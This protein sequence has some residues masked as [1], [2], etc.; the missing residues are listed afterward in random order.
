[1]KRT[2]ASLFAFAAFIAAAASA[3]PPPEKVPPGMG[4][5]LMVLIEPGTP[6]PGSNG[7]EVIRHVPEPDLGQ[8]GGRELHRHQNKRVI[9]LPLAAAKELRRHPSLL[10]LQRLWQGESLEGWDETAP[11]SSSSR[12]T[13]ET[14]VATAWGPRAYSYDRSGNITQ[15]GSDT[16]RYD[17]AGRL[18]SATVNGQTEQYTYDSFGNLTGKAITGRAA[19][20]IPVDS[21]SN[22]LVGGTYD[23]AG[24]LVRDHRGEQYEYDSAGMMIS[25][26]PAQRWVIYDADDEQIGMAQTTGYRKPPQYTV[27]TI[28]D[29]E[30]RVIREFRSFIPAPNQPEEYWEWRLDRFY[31]EGQLIAGERQ[32]WP[33][34]GPK[35]GG[36]RHYHLDHLGSV[37]MVTDEDGRSLSEDDYFPFGEAQTNSYQEYVME[38]A[39]DRMRF[40]GHSRDFLGLLNSENNEYLDNMHARHYD[41]HRGRFLSVDPGRDWDPYEP[42]S[43]NMYTYVRN[44]PVNAI[45]P[46]GRYQCSG[47]NAD[48]DCKQ[49]DAAVNDVA[50]AR[51]NLPQDSLERAALDATLNLLGTPN[52]GNNTNIVLTDDPNIVGQALTVDGVTTITLNLANINGANSA[53]AERLN[54]LGFGDLRLELGSVVAHEANHGVMERAHGM[55]QNAA[56][57]FGFELQA[58]RTQAIFHMG[59]GVNSVFAYWMKHTGIYQPAIIRSAKASTAEWC[60]R[61]GTC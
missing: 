25:A 51:N 14:D 10:Y 29:F 20:S 60:R 18:N 49:I 45:D 46:T 34:N 3:A 39:V 57:E 55:P 5:Y 48:E 7:K 40:A 32:R 33:E 23:A 6:K 13:A 19:V 30:G 2:I 54:I 61:A 37:R 52:D 24:N 4:K 47:V 43:W 35:W 26:T 16:F 8:A 21:T 58:Y 1:M 11:E 31:G 53:A 27:W 9:L 44:N 17:T 12:F 41:P 38:G 42:Q 28:R 15:I 22:R 56:Q 50:T 59:H 36:P